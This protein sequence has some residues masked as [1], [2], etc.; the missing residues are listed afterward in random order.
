MR[1][2]RLLFFAR[3]SQFLTGMNTE[4]NHAADQIMQDLTSGLTEIACS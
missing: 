3:T 1:G 2:R 4:V